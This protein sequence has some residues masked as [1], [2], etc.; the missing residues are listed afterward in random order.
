LLAKITAKLQGQSKEIIITSTKRNTV[1]QKK[2]MTKNKNPLPVVQVL[3]QE[4]MTS[5]PRAPEEALN[6]GLSPPPEN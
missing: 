4:G 1:K 6:T 2:R 5:T 3:V